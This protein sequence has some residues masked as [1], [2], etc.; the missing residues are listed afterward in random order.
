MTTLI[1]IYTGSK[2]VLSKLKKIYITNNFILSVRIFTKINQ[3]NSLWNEVK[4]MKLTR[5]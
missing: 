1:I 5:D 3:N 4:L 2:Q